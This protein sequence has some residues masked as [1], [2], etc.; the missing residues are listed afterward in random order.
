M[1]IIKNIQDVAEAIAGEIYNIESS[2]LSYIDGRELVNKQRGYPRLI[3]GDTTYTIRAAYGYIFMP[4]HDMEFLIAR[5]T[6]CI[7]SLDKKTIDQSLKRYHT[8]NMSFNTNIRVKSSQN[9][10]IVNTG[11][12][13]DGQLK[14]Y[15]NVLREFVLASTMREARFTWI[16]KPIEAF[17]WDITSHNMSEAIAQYACSIFYDKNDICILD[18]NDTTFEFSKK[19][20][21]GWDSIINETVEIFKHGHPLQFELSGAWGRGGKNRVNIPL[22]L[23]ELN[24]D[25]YEINYEKLHFKPVSLDDKSLATGICSEC[26]DILWGDNYVLAAHSSNIDDKYNVPICPICLHNYEPPLEMH[27][28]RLFRTTFPHSVYDMLES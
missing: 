19:L 9:R 7:Q 28:F 4:A 13:E 5:L 15:R 3:D 16:I 6:E 18:H 22:K 1:R 21:K 27:Y 26:H 17:D 14:K 20:L 8:Y 2:T 24:K 12:K 23:R 11:T 10:T 25:V